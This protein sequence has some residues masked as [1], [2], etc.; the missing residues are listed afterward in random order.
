MTGDRDVTELAERLRDAHAPV[1]VLG[2]DDTDY[3]AAW[4]RRPG[5]WVVAFR[6]PTGNA[7]RRCRGLH[8]AARFAFALAAAA[9]GDRLAVTY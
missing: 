7:G 9:P 4:L 3:V 5:E 6:V 2:A 1:Y 8:K